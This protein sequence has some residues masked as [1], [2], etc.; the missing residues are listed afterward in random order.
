MPRRIKG[1][2]MRLEDL[3]LVVRNLRQVLE[4][5]HN[6]GLE[7]RELRSKYAEF[8]V[9]KEIASRGYEVQVLNEREVRSADIYVPEIDKRIE[10]KSGLFKEESGVITTDASFGKGSQI[11]KR[12]FDVC[13]FVA[14]N[15]IN[16]EFYVFTL[17]E[18]LEVGE[19]ERVNIADH[20]DTNPCLLIL[21]KSYEDYMNY[22]RNEKMLNIEID[23]HKN[24]E[25]YK[26]RWD[27]IFS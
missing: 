10:V 25:K 22:L 27:K 20:P 24:P 18:L 3:E 9:T 2:L 12:K 1:T 21:C 11:R 6:S 19:N 4:V 7:D 15:G 26:D 23:L 14:F 13:V 8:L 17:E 5:L 16:P